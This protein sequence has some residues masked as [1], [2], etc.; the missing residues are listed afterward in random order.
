M[1]SHQSR[2]K[3][4]DDIKTVFGEQETD[5]I[6]KRI[7]ALV[8]VMSYFNAGETATVVA[9]DYDGDIWADFAPD[10]EEGRITLVARLDQ[11]GEKFEFVED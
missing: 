5:L 11:E 9:V 6:G 8:P 4:I 3:V 1:Y 2:E 7:R 10:E